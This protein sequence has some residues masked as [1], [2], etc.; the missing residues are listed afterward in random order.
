MSLGTQ[1][2]P[3]PGIKTPNL[4]YIS[5]K[6]G[7]PS[8]IRDGSGLAFAFWNPYP[9]NGKGDKMKTTKMSTVFLAAVAFAAVQNAQAR[10]LDASEMNN[11]REVLRALDIDESKLSNQMIEELRK[12]GH[13]LKFYDDAKSEYQK[14]SL[15]GEVYM[16]CGGG[17]HG[18]DRDPV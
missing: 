18:S 4:E 2:G 12:Q 1:G 9:I 14:K 3:G 16:T 10:P 5:R 6:A 11:V 7:R 13:D 17:S 15:E 8:Y